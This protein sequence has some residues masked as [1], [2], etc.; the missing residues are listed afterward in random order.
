VQEEALPLLNLRAGSLQLFDA[1]DAT[2]LY[3]ILLSTLARGA[4]SIVT[5]SSPYESVLLRDCRY[6][7]YLK[8]VVTGTGAEG[9]NHAK[10]LLIARIDYCTRRVGHSS[11]KVGKR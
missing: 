2:V 1:A 10:T 8:G 3:L 9:M 6:S 4:R 5:A 11:P 7:R